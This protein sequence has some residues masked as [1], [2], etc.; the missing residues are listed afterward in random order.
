MKYYKD[1]YYHIFNRGCNKQPIFFSDDNYIYLLKKIKESYQEFG[2]N[3]FAYC[4]MPNHYH[5]LI[6][7]LT[8]K[9]VSDWLRTIFGGYTQAINKQQERKGTLFEGRAKG[10]LIDKEEYLIHLMRYIH[11]NPVK[12]GL[13]NNSHDWK[14]SNY[15]ECAGLREGTLYNEKFIIQNFSSKIDYKTYFQYYEIENKMQNALEK[16]LID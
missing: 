10:I 4:L 3:I 7:Q 6:Q 16:Y 15:L 8:Y 12:A 5:F 9:P 1:N 11:N 14:Y 2:I 13:V